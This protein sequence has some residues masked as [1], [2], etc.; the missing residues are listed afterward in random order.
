MNKE[1][2]D[3]LIADRKI[4][5]AATYGSHL[6]FLHTYLNQYVFYKTAPF[7]KELISITEDN[8]NKLAVIVA[9]RGSA[10][11]T[12]MTQSL[13]MWS[14][15]GYLQ[16]K[17]ILIISQT[18]HQARMHLAN[19]KRELEGN[20]MLR[21]ELGPFQES[22]E[23]GAVSIV[24]PKYSARIMCAS[25]EQSIRGL[26][27]GQY[28]P[29]LII[30]DDVEDINSVKT[31]EGRDKTYRWL[32]SEVIPAGDKNTKII[33]I[34]NL[35]HED[36]L[37]MRLKEKIDSGELNGIFRS[38]P[39]LGENDQILW[40]GK[41][42][43]MGDI[44]ALKRTVGNEIAWQRE[45]LLR[46]I[47]DEGQ[48]IHSE[49]LHFYDELPNRSKLRYKA[50]GVDLAISETG[51]YTAMVSGAIYG[52]GK[53]RKIYILPNPI[54]ERLKFPGIIEKLRILANDK[55]SGIRPIYVEDTG[56]QTATIQQCV[57]QGIKVEPF[58]TGRSDKRSRLAL[59]T[60]YIHNGSIVFPRSG[61]EQLITQLTGFG[62]EKYD[63]LADGFSIL[64]L[65][66]ME[67]RECMP[68]VFTF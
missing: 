41:Y 61:A 11:S 55:G 45:Y 16:K 52:W 2:I 66:T 44:D 56:F 22:E 25:S 48:L 46:I 3:Q 59:T 26:R 19:I 65:K 30:C 6:L 18:Q 58:K 21:S 20:L 28:R 42:Q 10:K 50:T 23:W 4:R 49:W 12:I 54:N 7:Q 63:D 5:V 14:I 38:Y 39:L 9:F 53:E 27:H 62:V 57:S 47:P 43:T 32:T 33:I 15:I 1:L 34:G 31:K 68:E 13:P 60:E 37:L 36:S 64:A 51:D 29:D 35:L 17:F 67:K 40:P 8:N 24:I